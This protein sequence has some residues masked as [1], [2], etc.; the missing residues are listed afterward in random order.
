MSAFPGRRALAIPQPRI[1]PRR[2]LC[3]GIVVAARFMLAVDAL[4]GN[5]AV[6]A[7]RAALAMSEAGIEAVTAR[8]RIA[9]VPPVIA[10]GRPG[11]PRGRR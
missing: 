1:D 3:L 7:A 9:C 6:P 4:F 8:Y 11:V 2:W 10:G 5:V